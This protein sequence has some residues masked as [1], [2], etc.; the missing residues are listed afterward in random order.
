MIILGNIANLFWNNSSWQVL[1]DIPEFSESVELDYD[2][3]L[4]SDSLGEIDAWGEYNYCKYK[5]NY[6]FLE[7]SAIIDPDTKHYKYT[8]VK[9][10]W[11]SILNKYTNIKVSGLAT[12]WN[13]DEDLDKWIN[14]TIPTLSNPC[15]V[16]YI[17]FGDQKFKWYDS[18]KI[19]K[20]THE[21]KDLVLSRTT[22]EHFINHYKNIDWGYRK[23]LEKENNFTTTKSRNIYIAG[24]IDPTKHRG[25]KNTIY[26]L[27]VST[28]DSISSSPETHILTKWSSQNSPLN[29]KYVI[30]YK[31]HNVGQTDIVTNLKVKNIDLS[32]LKDIRPVRLDNPDKYHLP[33]KN[34]DETLLFDVGNES[35]HYEEAIQL[36]WCRKVYLPIENVMSLPSEFNY[37]YEKEYIELNKSQNRINNN[38]QIIKFKDTNLGEGYLHWLD[39][40]DFCF[41][42]TKTWYFNKYTN[43]PN[44]TPL[45]ASKDTDSDWVTYPGF[46]EYY[47][48]PGYRYYFWDRFGPED[49]FPSYGFLIFQWLRSTENWNRFIYKGSDPIRRLNIINGLKKDELMKRYWTGRQY[50][51]SKTLDDINGWGQTGL[52]NFTGL[53]NEYK[54]FEMMPFKF[55]PDSDVLSRLEWDLNGFMP[56]CF[57]PRANYQYGYLYSEKPLNVLGYIYYYDGY[58]YD[59]LQAYS[60]SKRQAAG[61][62]SASKWLTTYYL[63]QILNSTHPYPQSTMGEFR[64]AI[65]ST[66]QNPAKLTIADKNEYKNWNQIRNNVIEQITYTKQIDLGFEINQK[67]YVFSDLEYYLKNLSNH[68]SLSWGIG[69]SILAMIHGNNA[70]EWFHAVDFFKDKNEVDPLHLDKKLVIITNLKQEWEVR[71]CSC[72][73]FDISLDGSS[74]QAIDYILDSET[75]TNPLTSKK[76][77]ITHFKNLDIVLKENPDQALKNKIIN[78]FYQ[79]QPGI[80]EI[81]ISS[82]KTE[83]NKIFWLTDNDITTSKGH[84]FDLIGTDWYAFLREGRISFLAKN[85]DNFEPILED[86]KILIVPDSLKN[87]SLL[88]KIN[89]QNTLRI[90]TNNIPLSSRFDFDN[91]PDF[92]LRM[93]A[94]NPT[95]TNSQFEYWFIE[96]IG[97]VDEIRTY[98]GTLKERVKSL[99]VAEQSTLDELSLEMTRLNEDRELNLKRINLDRERAEI[100]ATNDYWD[101]GYSR[102]RNVID[103]IF[104]GVNL[105][106]GIGN[107]SVPWN[108]ASH[109]GKNSILTGTVAGEKYGFTKNQYMKFYKGAELSASKAPGLIGN[110]TEMIRIGEMERRVEEQLNLSLKQIALKTFEVDLTTIRRKEDLI[111]RLESSTN[112][113][114]T[115]I[116]S[117][118]QLIKQ[119]NEFEGI[120][121]KEDEQN[122]YIICRTP[123]QTQLKVLEEYKEI[124]GIECKIPNISL[125]IRKGMKPNIFRFVF[126]EQPELMEITD[127]NERKWLLARLQGGMC[128]RSKGKEIGKEIV[129]EIVVDSN[130]IKSLESELKTNKKDLL[131]T[132]TQLVQQQKNLNIANETINSF[133]NELTSMTNKFLEQE[134]LA[135]LYKS[136]SD[137]LKKELANC[138]AHNQH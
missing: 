4:R 27:I 3:I 85:S 22:F 125:T 35:P 62:T 72:H 23:Y 122:K 98:I 77:K 37:W 123:N 95:E 42:Y 115:P 66:T 9:D 67:D 7:K 41:D 94:A 76:I 5:N 127:L 20:P 71:Y 83:L 105:F 104:S 111:K 61:P 49:T 25:W 108:H 86:S 30:T 84:L 128:V 99:S 64:K 18:I 101:L 107:L 44:T 131:D 136:E 68:S 113:Y 87:K 93:K 109:W 43:K 21:I 12:T 89:Q 11:T 92:H 114:N 137:R 8:L 60:R 38:Q 82:S 110:I 39:K 46:I 6:Y 129:P 135:L 15:E 121:T 96:S 119:F 74:N 130:Y 55:S 133:R 120:S 88:T 69:K 10:F 54:W 81:A 57:L 75:S 1:N 138:K 118:R 97:P 47:N 34:V 132:K 63:Y 90:Y 45:N 80:E 53:K 73:E 103:Y 33:N 14:F 117:D 17:K 13:I 31:Q 91:N 51:T 16:N 59:I 26:N 36:K 32:N 40:V 29:G 124:F 116:I 28:L 106:F 19:F 24:K 2:P 134:K 65:T 78:A 52:T 50:V 79:N 48:Q 102:Y 112:I 56:I 100:Q 126:A 70:P 58:N